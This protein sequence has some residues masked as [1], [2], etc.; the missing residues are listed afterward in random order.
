MPDASLSA[1]LREAYA[2]APS[3]VV[4]YA[5]IE[6][7]HPAFTS[8]I[9]VVRDGSDLIATLEDSAPADAGQSVVFVRFA[10]NFT[11]PELS[12]S[13]VPQVTLEIDNVD[14]GIVANLEAALT[15]Q[16]PIAITYREYVSS[17]LSA[18]ANDPP[19]HMTL[20]SVTAD[21]LKV[22]ATAGFPDLVNR[23]FPT[24]EYQSDTFP[25]LAS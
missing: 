12:A 10:F 5:T 1:A 24:L 16:E 9:R 6:I 18:P 13:G 21:P 25:G 7:R 11:R 3:D 17:D 15:T 14:R 20:I 23:R 19:L 2:A 8:P 22:T 4:I